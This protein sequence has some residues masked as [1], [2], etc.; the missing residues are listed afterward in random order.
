MVDDH[1]FKWDNLPQIEDVGLTKNCLFVDIETSGLQ[2]AIP[3]ACALSIGAVAMDTTGT[4]L[5]EFYG[6][7]CPTDALIEK[8]NPKALEVNGWTEDALRAEG[9]PSEEVW[10]EFTDWLKG[11]GVDHKWRYIGQNPFFDLA[12]I[13]YEAPHLIKKYGWVEGRNSV[14]D[15][16]EN[17]GVLESKVPP[18]VPYISGKNSKKGKKGNALAEALQVEPEPAVH[19]A[20]EGARLNYRNFVKMVRIDK[21]WRN[22]NPR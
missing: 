15:N 8:M 3:D 5:S 4:V 20:L 17:Y 9:K 11:L 1:S 7:I 12:F 22:Q 2:Y 21:Q 14:L 19:N 13:A 18:V 6:V 10:G 16:I